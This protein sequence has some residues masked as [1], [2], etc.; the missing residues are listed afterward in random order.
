MKKNK[1]EDSVVGVNFGGSHVSAGAVSRAGKIVTK[2][3]E[4]P[5]D[6]SWNAEAITGQIAL[7]I[8]TAKAGA[9]KKGY[10]VI[11]VGVGSPGPMD[12][13]RGVILK[14]PNLP[15]LWNW[16]LAAQLSKHTKL[17]V[18][19]NNDANVTVAGEAF[20]GVAKKYN[21]VYGV[22]LGT[23]YGHG[24]VINKKIFCGAHFM[25]MEHAVTPLDPDHTQTIEDVVSGRFIVKRYQELTGLT[26]TAKEID[27]AAWAQD[28]NA[29]KAYE[30]FGK[31]MAFSFSWVI[32]SLDPEIVV[33]GGKIAK[34]F[35]LFL[36]SLI[37][38][39]RINEITRAKLRIEPTKLW[40]KAPIIGAASLI[41]S[42]PIF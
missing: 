36:P 20:A 4:L 12:M 42:E 16:P 13:K 40:E 14:T 34:G 8:K 28:E 17:L 11:G 3:F 37:H 15:T 38:H 29:G 2:I 23:G 1:S 39:L 10:Y 32:N 22:T 19:V 7:A 25:A 9:E 6:A 30:E 35:L 33:I 26:K 24:L 5:I 18:R 41:Y 21:L 27:E 31:Y